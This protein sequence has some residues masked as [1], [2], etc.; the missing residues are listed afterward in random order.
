V[1]EALLAAVG[2]CG[3][4]VVPTQSC[5]LTDPANWSNPPVPTSWHPTIRESMPAFDVRKTPSE[6]MGVVAELIRTWPGATRSDHP[7]ASFAALGPS[8]ASLL[9]RQPLDD[10][11][12]PDSPLSELYA[13]GARVL[14]LG[15]THSA[16]TSLHFAERKAFG[17]GHY[18]TSNASP[19]VVDGERRWV[20]YRAPYMYSEDF[21]EL[22]AD[23]E[24]S[25][26]DGCVRRMLIGRGVIRLFEL[27]AV[28]DFGVQWLKEHRR[29]E[30][31]AVGG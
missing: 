16:N 4:L 15:V 20:E 22:G 2:P 8:A 30:G 3:T 29:G 10:P 1:V 7:T 27:R 21:E 26:S 23:F 25:G 28:V 6:H 17:D 5:G 18:R 24:R 11:F 9:N 13:A 31:R 14:L 19:I 12:G